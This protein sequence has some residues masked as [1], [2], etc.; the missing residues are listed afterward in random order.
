MCQSRRK[1]STNSQKNCDSLAHAIVKVR[2]NGKDLNHKHAMDLMETLYL[3]S[4]VLMMKEA[5]SSNS[6]PES[7]RRRTWVI[8]A[9]K[10]GSWGKK[11]H[12][13]IMHDVVVVAQCC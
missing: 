13:D 11:L 5:F 3:T 6:E 9:P 10:G 7:R 8:N 2:I 12:I 1:H 4:K